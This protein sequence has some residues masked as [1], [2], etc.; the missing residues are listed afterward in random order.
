MKT[1]KA[2]E[3]PADPKS[4]LVYGESGVGKTRFCATAQYYEPWSPSLL[5]VIGAEQAASVRDTPG[6][7]VVELTSLDDIE[8]LKNYFLE[9]QPVEGDYGRV[10]AGGHHWPRF[11]SLSFDGLTEAQLILMGKKLR[12][13]EKGR[14]ILTES[15]AQ[16]PPPA[17]MRD[18]GTSF[19]WCINLIR[20]FTIGFP[21]PVIFTALERYYEDKQSG[22][23]T[24]S[25]GIPGQP[26]QIVPSK[27]TVTMRLVRSRT[28]GVRP[29]DWNALQE[30]YEAGASSEGTRPP[31]DNVG[32]LWSD[33]KFKAINRL[34][35]QRWVFNPTVERL[36]NLA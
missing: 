2:S 17:V 12:S 30:L 22:D 33:G 9:D 34:G 32:L 15:L 3:A 24:V 26:S 20:Q 16:L 19:N 36:I 29:S 11:K 35:P 6:L 18:W 28:F 25:I 31:L 7:H 27:A 10:Y 13:S 4:I 1:Y 8:W 14:G 5:A 23:T 21:V